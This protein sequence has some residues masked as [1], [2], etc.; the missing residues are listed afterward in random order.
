MAFII[1]TVSGTTVE[2]H[3]AGNEGDLEGSVRVYSDQNYNLGSGG[4]DASVPFFAFRQ[5]FVG[6][7]YFPVTF[8]LPG[9]Y[10]VVL[11]LRNAGEIDY[12]YF[13]IEGASLPPPI[14]GERPLW[15]VR[16]GL[17][18]M[19]W[20]TPINDAQIGGIVQAIST[21]IEPLGY[22]LKGQKLI[23]ETT[24]RKG[25]L[26]VFFEETGT[27][28]VVIPPIVTA[29][30][31]LLASIALVIISV[32]IYKWIGASST[33]TITQAGV[34]DD[35][36]KTLKEKYDDGTITYEQYIQALKDLQEILPKPINWGTIVMI[37]GGLAIGA[38]L[39]KDVLGGK[40]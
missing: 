1:A 34:Y 10:V 40:R 28:P 7:T 8:P 18:R 2:F 37:L 12:Q 13:T 11:T 36:A 20:W 5:S 9:R 35:A 33:V 38:F 17:Y 30:T 27:L 24:S 31:L 21:V 19:P 29:I 4:T 14:P 26:S 23:W 15:E 6:E 16:I 32:G 3:A 25:L 22:R 39:L